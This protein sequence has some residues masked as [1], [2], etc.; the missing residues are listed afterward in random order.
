MTDFQTVSKKGATKALKNTQKR[1]LSTELQAY[2]LSPQ[3]LE[4]IAL[5]K[6]FPWIRPDHMKPTGTADL[7]QV[8]RDF[9]QHMQTCQAVL[10]QLPNGEGVLYK[11]SMSVNDIG[12]L[13][14]YQYI[15]F[16]ARHA[17]RHVQQ[18]K[19]VVKE[20]EQN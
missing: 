14:V 2:E 20:W 7:A 8:Q 9:L 1:D 19:H 3:K 15:L 10:D 12:K 5:H 16:L 13:D 6:S 4:E 17:Q 11:T 18:M